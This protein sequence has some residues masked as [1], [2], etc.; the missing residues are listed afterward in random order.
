MNCSQSHHNENTDY[1]SALKNSKF[2]GFATIEQQQVFLQLFSD[3]FSRFVSAS[4]V[5][6]EDDDIVKLNVGGKLFITTKST[7]FNVDNSLKSMLQ[8]G[9]FKPD[10]DG[11]YFIDRSPEYF[12]LILDYLRN[13]TKDLNL[14]S[15]HLKDKRQKVDFQYELDFYCIQQ[16]EID[17]LIILDTPT[18]GLDFNEA[19]STLTKQKGKEG[20][21]FASDNLPMNEKTYELTFQFLQV[22]LGKEV[23][24]FVG[25]TET[26]KIGTALSLQPV[27]KFR[28]TKASKGDS[29]TC[30]FN[31]KELKFTVKKNNVVLEN[32]EFS[33]SENWFPCIEMN[34]SKDEKTCLLLN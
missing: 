22:P 34:R 4:T 33:N 6:A 30:T 25:L 20:Y 18:S 2:A 14:L 3:K 24:V 5:P 8:S 21:I 31:T 12:P 10:L 15:S 32:I 27:P 9:N 29:Y 17:N 23:S 28:I 26:E 7:L 16:E 1:L 19:D 13:P 11:A